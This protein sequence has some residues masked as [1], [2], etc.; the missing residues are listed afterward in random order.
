VSAPASFLEELEN[1]ELELSAR[2]L[3]LL[4]L[5]VA[6]L[7]EANRC[8]NLT[9]IREAEEVW[10]RHVLESL[11]LGRFVRGA[12]RV[13]DIGSGGGLPGIPLAILLPGTRFALIEA[14]GKKARFLER[15]AAAL[16]MGNV[17]VHNGR[18][19][20]LARC[21]ELRGRFDVVVARAVGSLA[22]LV[23]LALPLLAPDGRLLAVKG[24]SVQREVD[25]AA[26]ALEQV[27][28][29]MV[30]VHP[31]VP[32]SGGEGSVAIV[33]KLRATPERYPRLPGVPG[34]K[35]LK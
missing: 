25:E 28:G 35:P 26:G 22:E 17:R 16:R 5:F 1:E 19:E 21:G 2:Q 7:L 4:G 27:G 6:A 18:S 10:R 32:R 14:T 23:E 8:F 12:G 15:T 30:G 24:R 34:K 33:R 20:T 31:L 9:A 29:G 11:A 3:E 13:A